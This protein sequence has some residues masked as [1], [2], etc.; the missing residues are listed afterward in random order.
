MGITDRRALWE[1]LCM[2]RPRAIQHEWAS[3]RGGGQRRL[4]DHERIST[5]EDET[6]GHEN[7]L[8]GGSLWFLHDARRTTTQS[9][10]QRGTDQAGP[11]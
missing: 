11:L 1:E 6:D 2:N 5:R 4:P 9:F 10:G 3:L 7:T 8:Q